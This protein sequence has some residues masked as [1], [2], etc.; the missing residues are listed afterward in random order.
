MSSIPEFLDLL[1]EFE[2]VESQEH[3]DRIGF[4]IRGKRMFATLLES[5]ASVNFKLSLEDQ[6]SFSEKSPGIYPVPN[7]FAEHGWTTF[8]LEKL[9]KELLF[10]AI[11]S[12]YK[13][14]KK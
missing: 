13:L 12:A 4:R 8:E 5:T 1:S 14:V 7:K 11:E 2:E 9:S 6:S 10:N 3:F